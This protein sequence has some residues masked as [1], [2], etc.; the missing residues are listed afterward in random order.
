VGS[1]YEVT[2]ST[3]TK[4][5]Y[6]GTQRIAMRTN[7][8]LNYLLGDHLGSTSLVT[9]SAGNS[10]FETR[11]KAWGEVRH[12]SGN[13]PTKYQY[14][15]E[16]SYESE[17][18]LYFYNARWYDSS[19]GRFAQ[20][21]TVV[22]NGAQ[23][24]DRYVYSLNNPIRYLD[25]SGHKACDNQ[26]NHGNCVTLKNS[27]YIDIDTKYLN[28]RYNLNLKGKWS[29]REL[30][31][32]ITTAQDIER[33]V[34]SIVG[35]GNGL[36]WMKKFMGGTTVAHA[37]KDTLAGLLG[38]GNRTT[39]WPWKEVYLNKGWSNED[40]AHELAEMWDLNSSV[41]ITTGGYYGGV[42]DQLNAAFGGDIMSHPFACRFCYD[43]NLGNMPLKNQWGSDSYANTATEDYFSESFSHMIYPNQAGDSWN[44]PNGVQD[45]LD[46][47]IFNET[48]P[49]VIPFGAQD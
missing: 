11:Y 43:G 14:T 35:V 12:A 13:T 26:D 7:G 40:F 23:S 15:G 29:L 49:L 36:E 17:F 22:P 8:T 30:D 47:Q 48:M 45:W 10:S 37:G 2:G 34:D 1:H 38:Q 44:M 9:D 42:A 39:S 25:P 24:Y 21:D 28:D 16:F 27:D 46:K 18:G 32:M 6:A 41:S 19:L 4:Y 20:A 31:A 33:Y 3:I 5:Y